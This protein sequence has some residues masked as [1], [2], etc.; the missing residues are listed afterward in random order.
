[1]TKP[2]LTQL[3][4]NKYHQHFILVSFKSFDE[5]K[6]LGALSPKQHSNVCV[7]PVWEEG[8]YQQPIQLDVEAAPQNGVVVENGCTEEVQFTPSMYL[9]VLYL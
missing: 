6:Y 9:H 7:V 2:L 4:G 8:Q 5:S 1:M 3:N